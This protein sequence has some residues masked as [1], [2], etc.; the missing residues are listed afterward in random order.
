M[1]AAL[2]RLQV[3]GPAMAIVSGV[4]MLCMILAGPVYDVIA[5]RRVHAAYVLGVGF[6]LGIGSITRMVAASD[7]WRAFAGWLIG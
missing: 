3:L 6:I 1:P 7:S 5:H 4:V 2:G